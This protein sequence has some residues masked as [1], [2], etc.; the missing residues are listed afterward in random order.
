MGKNL[1]IAIFTCDIGEPWDP[2]K[3]HQ[4]IGGSEEA[5]IYM[6]QA[7]ARLGHRITVFGFPPP[8][9]PH[10]A[11]E[12]NPR[13]VKD[14]VVT[15]PFDI[16][17][18]WRMPAMAAKVKSLCHKAYLWAHDIHNER[19]TKQQIEGFEDVLW[20]SHWQRAYWVSVNPEMYRFTNI[21]G[22][23]VFPD[24]FDPVGERE[25]PYS[26]IYSSSYMRGLDFLLSIW[27]EVVKNFP[28]ATLDIYYSWQNWGWIPQARKM[29]KQINE[30]KGV[31]EHGR[32]GH[33]QLH[34]IFGKTSFWTY[35]LNSPETFC[36]TALKAQLSG[37]IPVILAN[38]AL[39]ETVP[40]G[41]NCI[42]KRDYLPLLL[43][44]MGEVGSYSIE[45][46]KQ[47][48]A[49]VLEK[50]TWEKVAQRWIDRFTS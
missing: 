38:S 28:S 8:G 26:C 44:A 17:I 24:Q 4:G 37:S 23:G 16:G 10:S 40:H 15:E 47:M 3:V 36:C 43:K 27:S 2:E 21:F 25:N 49:F 45:K 11:K 18:S 41:Y 29:Q 6:G 20:L 12:A 30:L 39:C 7:L 19:L 31:K 42:L 46:R 32:I 35:P 22:T 50:Y 48:G 33:R 9:S 13:Y 5:I 34:Q 1:S 14:L